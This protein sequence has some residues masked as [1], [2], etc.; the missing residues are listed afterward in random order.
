MTRQSWEKAMRGPGHHA[1]MAALAL[2]VLALAPSTVSAQSNI[3]GVVRDTSGAV[4]PGVTVEASSSAL[5]EKTRT[6]V[7][8]GQG[9]YNI[10]D[11]RPGAYTVTFTLLGF[12]TL[13]REGIQLPASFTA[14][15]NADLQVGS[16][17]ETVSVTGE[18]PVVDLRSSGRQQT[19]SQELLA[20]VPTGSTAQSYA[21]LLPSVTQGLGIVSTAPNSFRWADLNF[22]GTREASTSVDGFD[23]SHRL[24]GE[25]SQY[26]VNEGMVQEIVVSLGSAGAETQGAGII[27]NAI[28]KSG[29]NRFSGSFSAHWANEDF[30]SDNLTDQL[31]ALNL[32]SQSVRK[33]WDYNPSFGGPIARD[34]LWFYGS[35]RNLG[36][37]TDTGIRRDLDPLDW[38]YTPDPSRPT[39]SEQLRNRNYSLRLTWQAHAK[40]T[41]T[42][43]GDH[44]PTNWDNRGG[45]TGGGR[46]L[47]APEVT[48]S[49]LYEPQF[50][51][52]ASWKS[53]MSNKLYLEGGVTVTKNKQWFS[54]NANDALTGQPVSP[55]LGAIAA[56]DLDNNWL[57]RGSHFIGN[58]NN[59]VGVRPRASA[60]YITGSHTVKVGLQMVKGNDQAERHR[61]GD[62]IVRLRTGRPVSIE[63]WGP[64]DR[65]SRLTS[66]GFY[67]QDQWVIKR[68][69]L[70][71]GLR[72]DYVTT[73]ADPQTLP[74]NTMLPERH[75]E[76]IDKIIHFHDVS[77]RLGVAYDLFGNNRTAVKAAVNRFLSP[78]D[79]TGGR[80]P[81]A[82]AVP[83]TTRDWEDRNGNYIPDCDFRNF[84]VNGECGR[85]QNLN[86]GSKVLN[87]PQFDP[88]VDGGFG[89]R[90]YSWEI[91]SGIQHHVMQG[92]GVELGYY[93][94]WQGNRQV[95]QNLLTQPS[96][97]IPYCVRTPLDSR[98]PGGGGQ[99]M[100]GFYD[101]DPN[102]V[103]RVQNFTTLANR[104]GK[105]V[106]VYD[107]IEVNLN[108]RMAGGLQFTGGTITQR[109]RTESCYTVNNPSQV[110][111]KNTPPFLTTLKLMGMYPLPVWDIQVSGSLQMLPGPA[112][113]GSRTYGRSEILRLP[114]GRQL[115]T[116]TVNLTVVEPNMV[117]TDHVNKVDIR[118]SKIVRIGGY[119]LTGSVDV[120][121]LL[122]GAGILSVN[123]TIGNSWQNP[124]QALGGRL[125]RLSWRID[126]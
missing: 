67:G 79:F 105:E 54:R 104:F 119:R 103:G 5:I 99:E 6:A 39:D 126:F 116:A 112:L 85:L 19:L 87:P 4:L 107:G 8:D 56:Q 32:T 20:S 106:W 124:T 113:N 86:F 97:Y 10:V 40:H 23:T 80:H 36:N 30:V 71:V 109:V 58:F 51:A 22:R 59:T 31:R 74:G 110:F 11:L 44:N 25:G 93:R 27:I 26:Q 111:C 55:D 7:T 37:A 28:P 29:G 21:V 18:A 84:E 90:Q 68:A 57:F 65:T 78:Q 14:T 38:V 45:T 60:S 91:T 88:D 46:T 61:I 13:R 75:F 24:N 101:L 63:V 42:L 48:V 1:R 72:Y 77:P 70:N 35:Y 76:G 69:T 114:P 122:N 81:T 117:Y 125:Y 12:Q 41:V 82:L 98:L 47:N 89:H 73:S 123:T 118:A 50:V 15:V 92:L 96:D 43:H 120:I 9:V 108:A 94:R 64:E 66:L 62:Y 33:S 49:G 83:N 53:P 16:L 2:A 102:L 3:T 52:G 121:N 95:T 100:C 115:S 34:T 17:A